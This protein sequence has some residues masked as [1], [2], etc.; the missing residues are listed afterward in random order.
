MVRKTPTASTGAQMYRHFAILTLAVTAVVGVF[1]DGES[2]KAAASE[3]PPPSTHS[4]PHAGPTELARKGVQPP[5]SFT[6]SDTFDRSFGEPMEAAGSSA[7][8]GPAE[9][10]FADGTALAVPASINA[11]GV[12]AEV[13]ARMTEEQKRDLIARDQATREQAEQPERAGQIASLSA[14]S[15]AR[16]GEAS[17]G[18]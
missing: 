14:A 16:A 8:A 2:R 3:L 6:A 4:S 11:Y 10:E 13:W 5:S 18:D 15:R 1:A 12:S 17:A 7:A 9:H